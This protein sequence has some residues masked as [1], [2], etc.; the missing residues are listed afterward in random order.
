[1][2]VDILGKGI[3]PGIGTLAP[4]YDVELDKAQIERLLN[5]S[6]FRL[7]DVETGLLITKGNV[8]TFF[9][10]NKMKETTTNTKK[11]EVPKKVKPIEEIKQEKVTPVVEKEVYKEPIIE[12]EESPEIKMEKPDTIVEVTAVSERIGNV[13]DIIKEEDNNEPISVDIVNEDSEIEETHTFSRKKK[14][15]RN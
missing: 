8:N 2:K 11:I 14:R 13:A 4:K 6:Q 15:R 12:I 10:P 5:Y 1:M 9:K 7:G 3:I